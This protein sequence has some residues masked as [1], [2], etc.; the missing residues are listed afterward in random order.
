MISRDD[1]AAVRVKFAL[2]FFL[3]VAL[4]ILRSAAFSS[5]SGLRGVDSPDV[6]P[7]SYARTRAPLRLAFIVA[8]PFAYPSLT[9][10]STRPEPI[11]SKIRRATRCAY[12]H[13][14][15]SESES[16][17]GFRL[18]FASWGYVRRSALFSNP[19]HHSLAVLT[20]VAAQTDSCLHARECNKNVTKIFLDRGVEGSVCPIFRAFFSFV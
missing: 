4:L 11:P 16:A 10:H 1:G 12:A 8:P 9:A 20:M 18:F 15:V 2:S 13:V 5:H 14:T 3:S 17:I 19:T 7:H 6:A